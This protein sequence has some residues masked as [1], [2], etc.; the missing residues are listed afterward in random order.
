MTTNGD[1]LVVGGGPAGITAACRIAEAGYTVRLCDA[2]PSLGGAIF[3]GAD[4]KSPLLSTEHLRTW[5]DI[6]AELLVH[7]TSIRIMTSTS[8]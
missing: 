1:I 6:N 2:A 8:F 7:A 5:R 3:R 4:A